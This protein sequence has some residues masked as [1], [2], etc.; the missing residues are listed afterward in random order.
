MGGVQ[1]RK[2]AAIVPVGLSHVSVKL[3]WVH[4][5]QRGA[6]VW[7]C[8][9]EGT[10]AGKGAVLGDLVQFPSCATDRREIC[11]TSPHRD[12][13]PGKQG[14]CFFACSARD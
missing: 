7:L 10:A 5:L 1:H 13:L 2:P 14:G 8:A 4:A 11:L 6:F 12:S 3:C 9:L